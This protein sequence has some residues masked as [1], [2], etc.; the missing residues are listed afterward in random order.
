[1]PELTDLS[2][3]VLADVA[4]SDAGYRRSDRID[5]LLTLTGKHARY[6]LPE[7]VQALADAGLVHVRRAGA[8]A[9]KPPPGY[10]VHIT[11]AGLAKHRA[12]MGTLR[13]AA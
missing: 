8:K 4:A 11:D 7:D 9:G 1:M 3:F 12:L 13:A 6:S 2:L 10:S 5:N